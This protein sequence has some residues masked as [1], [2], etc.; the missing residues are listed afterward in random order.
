MLRALLWTLVTATERWAEVALI[1]WARKYLTRWL[2]ASI[3]KGLGPSEPKIL[4][5][6]FEPPTV[7]PVGNLKDALSQVCAHDMDPQSIE[8]DASPKIEIHNTDDVS[9][10]NE[11]DPLIAPCLTCGSKS[12]FCGHRNLR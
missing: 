6:N 7:T 11:L 10:P 2:A 8:N 9:T 5:R 12:M 4:A 3:N 1:K